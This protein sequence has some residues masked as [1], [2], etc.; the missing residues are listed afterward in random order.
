MNGEDVTF[1]QSLIL[2]L[3]QGGTEFLPISSS[4]HLILVS[5]VMGWADQ[6]LVFDVAVHLGTLFAVLVYFRDDL[7][8]LLKDWFKS[9]AGQGLTE[10]G[11]LAWLL[12]YASLPAAIVGLLAEG[13]IAGTLRSS[14]VIATATLVFAWV[15]WSADKMGE[16]KLSLKELGH[17]RA[18]W[19]G[20]AQCLALIPGTSRSGITISMA[21]FCG[22]TRQAASKF[23]FLLSIPIIAGSGLLQGIALF[24]DSALGEFDLLMMFM[25]FSVALLTALLCIHAFLTL[26]DRIGFLPFIIYR[27]ILG[28]CLYLWVI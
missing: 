24:S 5:E 27:L 17:R 15:L 10:S 12:L 22:L 11:K 25:A 23:S 9:L 8:Q 13:L 20:F 7:A 26:I 4:A 2:A 28:I 18:L 19:I 3:V 1:F 6:G 16:C 21:L 14:A